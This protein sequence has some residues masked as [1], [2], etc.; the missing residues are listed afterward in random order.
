LFRFQGCKTD[1]SPVLYYPVWITDGGRGALS[2]NVLAARPNH[3]FWN[4]LTQSLMPYNWNWFFPYVTISYAS[5]QW[6][7]TSVWEEYHALLPKPD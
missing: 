4:L 5:G 2:N 6:F 3:P 1:L 7:V